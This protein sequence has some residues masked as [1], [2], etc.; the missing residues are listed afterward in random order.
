MK[1]KVGAKQKGYGVLVVGYLVVIYALTIS[2]NLGALSLNFFEF[3]IWLMEKINVITQYSWGGRLVLSINKTICDYTLATL[4]SFGMILLY[5]NIEQRGL[6]KVVGLAT[7][8]IFLFSVLTGL[9]FAFY[10][11]LSG[12][13][14]SFAYLLAN[15]TILVS[16]FLDPLIIVLGYALVRLP[17]LFEAAKKKEQLKQGREVIRDPKKAI[18]SLKKYSSRSG[19]P[20]VEIHPEIKI[21]LSYETGHILIMAKS[22]GGKTQILFPLLKNALERGDSVMVYDYKGDYTAAYA[23]TENTVI[24]SLF[25]QRGVAW[26]MARDVFNE[27]LAYEFACQLLPLP[28]KADPFFHKAAQDL[29]AGAIIGLQKKYSK[30][31]KIPDLVEILSNQHAIITACKAHRPGALSCLGNLDGKQAAGIFGMLR[32]ATISLEYL[33]K[34]YQGVTSFLSITEWVTGVDVR[35]SASLVIVKGD[36]RYPELNQFFVS[37]IFTVLIRSVESLEDSYSRRIWAILDEFGNIG[38]INDFDKM[39]STVRSKGMRIVASLQDISQVEMVYSKAFSQAFFNSFSILLAG[40]VTGETASFVAK[41]MGQSKK[42]RML[43]GESNSSGIRSEADRINLSESESIVTESTLLDSDF[44]SIKIPSLKTPA[45][46]W[47][48]CAGWPIGKLI[49]KIKPTLSRYEAFSQASWLEDRNEHKTVRLTESN[50]K[51]CFD[52]LDNLIKLEE[53]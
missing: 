41:A 2:G 22:G 23:G 36:R 33:G 18:R 44:S 34:A 25:D 42:R 24:V 15:K 46:F 11:L 21:P 43:S 27:A 12:Q 45:T 35:E 3:L 53:V 30:N 4:I 28:E 13:S 8:L 48:S 7:H 37:Q 40:L 14:D 5:A 1:Y 50:T 20:G 29:L 10:Y 26:D 51:A 49:Y 19:C 47:F 38:A 6:S 52:S 17:F 32:T 9:N 39:L 16:L 31:W